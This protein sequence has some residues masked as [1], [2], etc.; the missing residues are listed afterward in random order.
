VEGT[1]LKKLWASPGLILRFA[2]LHKKDD[3]EILQFAREWGVLCLCEHG[4][5]AWHV[6]DQC[7][8]LGD[9]A[10]LSGNNHEP[11]KIWRNY[12]LKAYKIIEEAAKIYWDMA[13]PERSKDKYGIWNRQVLLAKRIQSWL[14]QA[15]VKIE[16]FWWHDH[17]KVVLGTPN[18]FAAL[19]VQLMSLVSRGGLA[20]CSNCG[21][22]Y[23]PKRAPRRDQRNYCGKNECKKVAC[24][25]DVKRYKRRKDKISIP[26]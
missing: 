20:I 4:L 24:W 19:S 26:R 5:P 25:R 7:L 16:Y 9:H 11:I 8:P 2:R 21:V 12:S 1:Q 23:I 14:N 18:L 15:G 17:Q 6:G 10:F 13:G 3:Y 22:V